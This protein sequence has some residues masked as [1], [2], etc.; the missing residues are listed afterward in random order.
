MVTTLADLRTASRER[1]RI[2]ANDPMYPDQV[3]DRQLNI[4][5]NALTCVEPN[6]WWWQHVEETIQNGATDAATFPLRLGTPDNAR[7][8]RK[9]LYVFVSLDGNYWLPVPN[10]ERQDQIRLAGGR[11]VADGI[12]LSWSPLNQPQ[13]VSGV[14]SNV[15]IVF[16][17]PLPALAWVR[18]GVNAFA[19]DLV[20]GAA[21]VVGWPQLLMDAI[22]ERAVCA[23]MRQKRV[24]ATAKA[25]RAAAN[26]MTVAK[27]AADGWVKAARIY[28]NTAAAGPG[29]TTVRPLP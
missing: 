14:K 2:S 17:P 21:Q 28:F 19:A 26:E 5:Y 20:N 23:L 13:T 4:A 3:V 25:A 22:T 8:V 10:R 27:D 18:Y 9:V 6:G 12:P 24:G 16:D 1:A 7:L 29:Y 15:S 11:R